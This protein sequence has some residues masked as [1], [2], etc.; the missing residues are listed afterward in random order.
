LQREIFSE[1]RTFD[2][3]MERYLRYLGEVNQ[4]MAAAA[5]RVTEVVYGI[6]LQIKNV[7]NEL[8]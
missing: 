3:D 2:P 4:R 5:D 6:P 8:D 1:G 7:K